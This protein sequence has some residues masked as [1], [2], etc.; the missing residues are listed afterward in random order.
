MH[1]M[2]S[3]LVVAL[4][5]LVATAVPA[6]ACGYYSP[7]GT[8]YVSPCGSPCAPAPAYVSPCGSPCAPAYVRPCASTYGCRIVGFERLA[9]PVRAPDPTRYYYVD[10]GPTFT[11]PGAF[12]PY[13][14]YRGRV[15]IYDEDADGYGPDFVYQCCRAPSYGQ[16]VLRSRY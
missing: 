2:V 9:R 4:A 13:P 1:R 11:G 3:G 5:A 8:T 12:A 6:M 14:T 10:Q 16:P 7:C 15:V